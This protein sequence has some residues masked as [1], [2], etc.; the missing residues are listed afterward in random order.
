MRISTLN[1]FSHADSADYADLKCIHA[2]HN[3]I[4]IENLRD[5]QDPLRLQSISY[6]FD[7]GCNV[8][9]REVYQQTKFFMSKNNIRFQLLIMD[10]F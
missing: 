7:V 4:R 2:L 6:S 1:I 9:C 5:P 3:S 8:I 10:W